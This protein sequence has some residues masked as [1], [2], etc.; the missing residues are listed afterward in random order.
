MDEE[1][2][3]SSDPSRAGPKEEEG[4]QGLMDR[5]LD[6]LRMLV[7]NAKTSLDRTSTNAD[8]VVSEFGTELDSFQEYVGSLRSKKEEFNARI[9]QLGSPLLIGSSAR[10]ASAPTGGGGHCRPEEQEN[11]YVPDSNDD[12]V[13]CEDHTLFQSNKRK[14]I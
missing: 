8:T 11:G 6:D 2:C 7:S 13:D 9:R 5:N 12:S 4:W 14:T 1:K 10:R 3:S